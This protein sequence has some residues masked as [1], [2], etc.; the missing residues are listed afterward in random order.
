MATAR[1][2]VRDK[3]DR[4]YRFRDDV[5]VAEPDDTAKP[6]LPKNIFDSLP[7]FRKVSFGTLDELTCYMHSPPKDVQNE[8]VLK[9]WHE[10]QNTYPNLHRM[11]FDYH[12]VPS[13]TTLLSFSDILILLYMH[14]NR[15]LCRCGASLQSRPPPFTLHPQPPFFQINTCASVHWRLEPARFSKGCR[16]QTCCTSARHQQ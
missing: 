2:I 3:F 13:K 5:I 8:D 9:W 12:T 4:C 11:A 15:H 1:K 6:S 7:A 10:H 14:M 16:H